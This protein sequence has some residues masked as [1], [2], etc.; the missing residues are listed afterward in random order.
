MT[1]QTQPISRFP[2]FLKKENID[3]IQW[4][5]GNKGWSGCYVNLTKT[6]N[7]Y[8]AELVGSI[9]Q[10]NKTKEEYYNPTSWGRTKVDAINNLIRLLNLCQLFYTTK[11]EKPN[12]IF[13]RKIVENGE[14]LYLDNLLPLNITEL[15]KNLAAKKWESAGKPAGLDE[16]FWLAA[17]NEII[18]NINNLEI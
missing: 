1:L 8:H 13:G 2:I 5:N 7:S 12:F 10:Y 3:F 11:T 9:K 18:D 16:K 14:L 17:E 6:T 15:T 4:L